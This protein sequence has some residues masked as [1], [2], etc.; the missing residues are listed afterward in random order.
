MRPRRMLLAAMLCLHASALAQDA[1]VQ[2]TA[3]RLYAG[4]KISV[5]FQNVGVR[6]ALHVLADASGQNIIASDS[7]S[8]TS[9]AWRLVPVLR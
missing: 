9:S 5:D 8:R 1:V 6:A 3:P 2:V 4:D 7:N